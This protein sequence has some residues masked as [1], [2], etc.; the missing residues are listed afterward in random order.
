VA[1][2]PLRDALA[3]RAGCIST[4]K[5]VVKLAQ[6]HENLNSSSTLN[7]GL[8]ALAVEE[9]AL[10]AG[11]GTPLA[12]IAMRYLRP[13]RVGPAVATASVRGG[14]G[15]VEVRDEGRHSGLSVLATTRTFRT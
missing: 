11:D 4:E 12:M 10:S 1:G 7:G 9:A 8:L 5:G 13:V 14:L 3:E 15:E 2:G 6:T